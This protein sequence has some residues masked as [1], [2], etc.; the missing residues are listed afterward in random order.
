LKLRGSSSKNSRSSS[1]KNN[2]SNSKLLESIDFKAAGKRI[3]LS[4]DQAM[5]KLKGTEPDSIDVHA[6]EI[7]G[8]T[9]PVKQALA[10]I[11]DLDRLDLSTNQARLVLKK[12]GFKVTRKS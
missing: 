3:R 12:L 10:V 4:K 11:T 9:Y 1:S 5:R 6:V 2:N 7:N 8:V